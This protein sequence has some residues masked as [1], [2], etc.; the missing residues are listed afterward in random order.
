MDFKTN[1]L[2]TFENS[3][4]SQ[5]ISSSLATLRDHGRYLAVENAEQEWKETYT[6]EYNNKII[7]VYNLLLDCI[8]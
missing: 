2:L 6:T 5:Y 8:F 4:R 3:F 1:T 7:Y